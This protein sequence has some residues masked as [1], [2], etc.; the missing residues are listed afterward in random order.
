[1]K[2]MSE[3][4]FP[5]WSRIKVAKII[6]GL[7]TGVG[8]QKSQRLKVKEKSQEEN[9]YSYKEKKS[10]YS[11]CQMNDFSYHYRSP[12]VYSIILLDASHHFVSQWTPSPG[13]DKSPRL[14]NPNNLV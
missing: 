3:I 10:F 4:V 9:D 7:T 6:Q 12:K 5:F 2:E 14:K 1:M 13:K 11:Y 8:F